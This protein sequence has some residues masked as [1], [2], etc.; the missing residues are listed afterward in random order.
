VHRACVLADSPS[1]YRK[2]A[3]SELWHLATEDTEL[4]Q[5]AI[6]EIGRLLQRHNQLSSGT[7][8]SEWLQLITAK[9]LVEETLEHE[10]MRSY[11]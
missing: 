1:P 4:L 3:I 8:D 9:R 6:G 11:S 7:A 2:Q 5:A 10:D